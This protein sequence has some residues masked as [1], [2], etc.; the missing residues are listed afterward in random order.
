MELMPA[1]NPTDQQNLPAPPSQE[2]WTGLR[3][4]GTLFVWPT[5]AAFVGA[6]MGL[7]V[8]QSAV[9]CLAVSLGQS[10]VIENHSTT[11]IERVQTRSAL[12][13]SNTLHRVVAD[14]GPMVFFYVDP[15]G[16]DLSG[17]VVTLSEMGASIRAN[18]PGEQELIEGLRHV[19]MSGQSESMERILRYFFVEYSICE[20]EI[21]EQDGR[22]IRAVAALRDAPAES[23]SARNMAARLGMSE[24]R[25]LHLFREQTGMPFRRFKIWNR[26]LVAALVVSKGGTLTQAAVD[27]GFSTPSHFSTA[28]LNM[29]GLPP[30]SLFTG[31][32]RIQVCRS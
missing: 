5:C 13:V 31:K 1:E 26:M 22:I 8:H 4:S 17:L 23:H 20:R 7:G 24:S 29:F 21:P 2:S 11:P 30:S 14:D 3:S 16:R 10:F 27:A 25:F 15:L 9:T 6:S 32:L 18:L 19:L 12:I 28:F